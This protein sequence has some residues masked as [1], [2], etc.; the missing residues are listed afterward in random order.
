MRQCAAHCYGVLLAAALP[1]RNPPCSMR[2]LTLP[3][4]QTPSPRSRWPSW[5]A[6]TAG[7]CATAAGTP[8]SP[9]SPPVRCVLALLLACAPSCRRHTHSVGAA[10]QGP[11]APAMPWRLPSGDLRPPFNSPASPPPPHQLALTAPWPC[12]SQRC[13]EIWRWQ[14]RRR[15]R[16]RSSCSRAAGSMR[17]GAPAPGP[18]RG[19]RAISTASR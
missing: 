19:P 9:S 13:R 7:V 14:K 4:T 12:G 15:R 10:L 2:A 3:R 18:C 17:L 8:T 5:V 6:T 16:R 1:A 11:G